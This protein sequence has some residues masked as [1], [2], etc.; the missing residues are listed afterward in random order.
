MLAIARENIE[1]GVNVVLCAPFSREVRS[2]CFE[3]AASDYPDLLIL[4]NSDWNEARAEQIADL[5][6]SAAAAPAP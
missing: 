1:V 5:I 3:P 2:R 6:V 4:D